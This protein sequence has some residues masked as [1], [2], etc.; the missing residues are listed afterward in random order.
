MNPQTSAFHLAGD[1]GH[2]ELTAVQDRASGLRAV[3]ALDHGGLGTAVGGS[4]MRPYASYA[5]D[6]LAGAGGL[7]ALAGEVRG[8]VPEETAR[9]VGEIGDRLV[10]L[11]RQS[12]EEGVPVDRL[13]SK[14]A[15]E[16]RATALERGSRG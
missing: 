11:W 14:L 15:E 7:L 12:R 5:P 8:E 6:V 10:T 16:K 1:L 13:A 3:I 4:R 9:R 2:A